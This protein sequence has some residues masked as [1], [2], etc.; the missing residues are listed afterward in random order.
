MSL[1]EERFGPWKPIRRGAA[2]AWLVA[3]ALFFLYALANSSGFLFIDFANLAIHEAG[4]PFFGLFGSYGLMILGGT[5]AELLVPFLCAAYFFFRREIA[6]FAF[7][8]FWLFE[9]FLYIGTYMSDA[10]ALALP[11]VGSGDHDWNILFG[12][13]GV[14]PR[15]T[16]IGSATRFLGWVGML[17]VWI[18]LAWRAFRASEGPAPG[19][20]NRSG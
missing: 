12:L 5:L 11:L 6:G 19:A 13:W 1:F 18:W 2:I 10:R 9:N 14:L 20:A 7:A 4:H 16:A 17:V 8:M 15:D 3:Y